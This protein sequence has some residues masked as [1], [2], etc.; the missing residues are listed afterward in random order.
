M[1][2]TGDGIESSHDD[3]SFLGRLS[4]DLTT[5]FSSAKTNR[6]RGTYMRKEDQ[7]YN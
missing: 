1:L 4:D 2:L 3:T 5:P 6:R 7:G